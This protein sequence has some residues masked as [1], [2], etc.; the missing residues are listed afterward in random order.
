MIKTF[1]KYVAKAWEEAERRSISAADIAKQV[2]DNFWGELSKFWGALE[3]E[4]YVEMKIEKTLYKLR[5]GWNHDFLVIAMV[6]PWL[7]EWDYVQLYRGRLGCGNAGAGFYRYRMRKKV[8]KL[9]LEEIIKRIEWMSDNSLEIVKRDDELALRCTG[10][11]NAAKTPLWYDEYVWVRNQTE[12]EEAGD[13][14]LYV[15]GDDHI[16]GDPIYCEWKMGS[17]RRKSKE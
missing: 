17:M 1:S 7:N 16:W 4:E 12:H 14:R 11:D 13:M 10:G 8:V 15:A 6:T 5:C 9:L 3:K 2:Q